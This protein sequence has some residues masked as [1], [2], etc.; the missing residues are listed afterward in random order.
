MG[1]PEAR[2]SSPGSTKRRSVQ[3]VGEVGGKLKSCKA[4]AFQRAT[5]GMCE[6][7]KAQY[8][9][10]RSWSCGNIRVLAWGP[11][12]CFTAGLELRQCWNSGEAV[13]D[14]SWGEFKT[15]IKCLQLSD[16]A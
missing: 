4:G 13:S 9:V 12:G 8:L 11:L 15:S 3:D 10:G 14:K 7:G 6:D 2:P 5:T 1:Q 16:R